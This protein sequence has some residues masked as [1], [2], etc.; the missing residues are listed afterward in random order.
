MLAHL[1]TQT[2]PV[3]IFENL[4]KAYVLVVGMGLSDL[5]AVCLEIEL[6]CLH[7]ACAPNS[8]LPN[9]CMNKH[10]CSKESRDS[11]VN[12]FTEGYSLNVSP[13]LMV[14]FNHQ[15]INIK[16]KNLEAGEMTLW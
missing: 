10:K 13:K 9:K 3:N 12:I 1:L 8:P 6:L 15:Y 7:R 4:M 16:R 11:V 2:L 5:P 14:K